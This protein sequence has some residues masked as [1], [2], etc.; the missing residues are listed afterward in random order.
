MYIVPDPIKVE[1]LDEYKIFI[2]FKDG[3]K[4]IFDM[5]KYINQEFYKNLK[6]RKYFEKVKVMKNTVCWQNGE[7][8]A[9]EDLYNN[10]IEIKE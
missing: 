4:K 8:I 9:P 2:E 5:E 1:A 6:D 3:K 7:D 10:S